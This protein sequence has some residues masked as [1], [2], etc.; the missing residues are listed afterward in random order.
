MLENFAT[1]SLP[2]HNL[3]AV[4]TL[5]RMLNSTAT[6]RFVGPSLPSNSGVCV[7]TVVQLARSLSCSCLVE[8]CVDPWI[9]KPT[10]KPTHVRVHTPTHTGSAISLG[11]GSPPSAPATSAF[12]RGS[13]T[14]IALRDY[15]QVGRHQHVHTRHA[16]KSATTSRHIHC[17]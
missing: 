3:L 7:R 9:H 5:C 11:S 15:Q 8:Q 17:I 6:G 14:D 2:S 13:L 10:H 4:G 1:C 16:R 12:H